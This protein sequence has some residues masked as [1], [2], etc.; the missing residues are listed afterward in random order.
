MIRLFFFIFL[1]QFLCAQVFWKASGE[2]GYYNSSGSLLEDEEELLTRINLKAGYNYKTDNNLVQINFQL[3]PEIYGF[4]NKLQTTRIGV[5][6]FFSQARNN[7]DWTFRLIANKYIFSGDIADFSYDSFL[8]NSQIILPIESHISVDTKVGLAYRNFDQRNAVSLDIMFS[9]IDF[10]FSYNSFTKV[11][12]G[13]YLEKFRLSKEINSYFSIGHTNNSG[14]RIGPVFKL[15]YTRKFVIS[16]DYQFLI[17]NSEYT[18]YPSYDQWLRIIAGT[19]IV[20]NLSVFVLVDYYKR[21]FKY[22]KE[23]NITELLYSPVNAENRIFFRLTKKV[24]SNQKIF[25]KIGYFDE[26]LF[27]RNYSLSG[28]KGYIGFELKG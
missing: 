5:D 6:G 13:L 23:D 2:S 20:K 10:I 4:N 28:W 14:T 21:N 24:K 8:I 19:N 22:Q 9:E 26:K 12:C 25:L 15:N 27:Y 1:T 3:R 11:G 17:H 7:F 16:T 18:T